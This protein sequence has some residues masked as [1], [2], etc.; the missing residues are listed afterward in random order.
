MKFKNNDGIKHPISLDI[1]DIKILKLQTLAV[2]GGAGAWSAWGD[3]K[4]K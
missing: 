3:P 2:R 4:V 1:T